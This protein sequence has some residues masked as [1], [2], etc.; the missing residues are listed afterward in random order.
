MVARIRT[1]G[2]Y[3]GTDDVLELLDVANGKLILEVGT[4]NVDDYYPGFV[5]TWTPE[6]MAVNSES[7]RE[8]RSE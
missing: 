3:S 2:E 1:K 5:A 6:N 7:L 4:S 8:G